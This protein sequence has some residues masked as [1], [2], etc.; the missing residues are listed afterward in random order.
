MFLHTSH[1]LVLWG[2]SWFHWS[3]YASLKKNK[4]AEMI[5]ICK[6]YFSSILN[7]KGYHRLKYF[8]LP[9]DSFYVYIILL[10]GDVVW[11][12]NSQKFS[13]PLQNLYSGLISFF[14]WN[15]GKLHFQ[16]PVA[17]FS[18]TSFLL[19]GFLCKP[20]EAYLIFVLLWLNFDFDGSLLPKEI[21]WLTC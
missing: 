18:T 2:I 20:F 4:L 21:G 11:C 12:L 16:I 17:N 9:V 6:I 13:Y 3:L 14:F 1:A 15:R 7:L 19:F 8:L 5:L 10:S